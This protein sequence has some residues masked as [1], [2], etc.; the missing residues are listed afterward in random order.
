MDIQYYIAI[1]GKSVGP[2]SLMEVLMNPALTADTLVWKTGMPDW[3]AAKEFQELSSK[4]ESN[5]EPPEIKDFASNPQYQS[6]H[7]YE[8]PN[9]NYRTSD[10]PRYQNHYDYQN[11]HD[12]YQRGYNRPSVKTNWLPWAIVAT[13]VGF[14]TSCIGAIFGII[15]IVQANKANSM[16]ARGM[17]QEGD[18]AN[19]TARIMTIIGLVLAGIGILVAGWFSYIFTSP[20]H[21][22]SY[23]WS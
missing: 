11:H 18:A 8:H 5:N 9:Q 23:W 4:F 1:D 19:S 13:I 7:K 2:L 17:E 16:Y 12:P 20:G 15:G 22:S 21:F 3:K 14:F 10:E 6:G